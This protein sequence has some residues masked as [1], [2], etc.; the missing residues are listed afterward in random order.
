MKVQK[1]QRNDAR[2]DTALAGKRYR[3]VGMKWAMDIVK[4]VDL[5][6]LQL[7]RRSTSIVHNME[8]K[9]FTLRKFCYP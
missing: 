2:C 7:V 8:H 6:C 3:T 4:Y 9:Q 5:D 1:P